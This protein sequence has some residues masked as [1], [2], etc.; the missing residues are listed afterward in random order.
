MNQPSV[1]ANRFSRVP[2]AEIP[3]SS[4]SRPHGYKTT[5]DAGELI[6]IF[7]DEALPGDTLNCKMTAFARLATPLHP[8]MDN[9][10][11]NT[12]FFAIPYRLIWDN[13]EKMNGAQDNPSDS[14]DFLVPE[15]VSPAGGYLEHSL[16]DYFGL[17]TKVAGYNHNSLFHRAY[18]LTW[19]Q[20][21]RDQNLQDSLTVDK[22]DGPDDPANYTVQKRGKRHDYFTSALP[23]PQKG[24]SVDIPIGTS[25]PVAGFGTLTAADGW[26]AAQGAN[27]FRRS[28]GTTSTMTPA[29]AST[30]GATFFFEEHPDFPNHPNLYVDL[31]EATAATINQLRQ[32]YQ[33]QKLYE[34]D[35]RGGTRYVEIILS[36][37]G[38]TSPD[39]RLQ[40]VEYLGGG[41]SPLNVNPVAQTSE[42]ATTPQG[43]L[44]AI[45]TS[46]VSGHGFNKSFPDHCLI[47]GLVCARADL[48]YQQGLDRMFSRR[49]RWD[50]Y[51]PALSHIGE[52]TVLS[53]EIYLDGTAN[54]E[55][56]FGYQERFAEYRYKPSK[57]TG[58]FRS[59]AATPLDTWHLSQDFATRPVLNDEFIEEDPPIDRVIAVP[60]EP[61][62]LF[63]AY[64]DLKSARPMPMYGIPG[65]VDHF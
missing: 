4:F 41:Q 49:N 59:N 38:V 62:F 65:M 46:T 31:S 26:P 37:F 63:D 5:F 16:S 22:G 28:D 56:V 23:W 15:M 2:Q 48:T 29:T 12:F 35:A 53:K 45:G 51:W 25:A 8:F 55:D 50:F 39:A 13:W 27:Q 17:P 24:D 20:W 7:L 42:A 60:S 52:Q 34:R 58:Q 21:F 1:M 64:F 18:N 36:H 32:A 54:D 30:V 57:I 11:L 10:F 40:R 47:L 19:N 14:T 61:H 6:P 44:A 43:N 33:I 9:V 3:R